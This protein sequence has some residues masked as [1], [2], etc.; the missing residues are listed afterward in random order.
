MK[1]FICVFIIVLSFFQGTIIAQNVTTK[2]ETLKHYKSNIS[3]SKITPTENNAGKSTKSNRQILMLGTGGVVVTSGLI[4]YAIFNSS[5]TNSFAVECN[6]GYT[7]INDLGIAN[8]QLEEFLK[9]SSE[10]PISSIQASQTN[11][12]CQDVGINSITLSVT[13]DL[14]QTAVCEAIVEVKDSISPVLNCPSDVTSNTD[15]GDCEATISIT[16][17]TATDNC[18]LKEVINDITNSSDPPESFQQGNTSVTWIATD[19]YDNFSTCK[20]TISVID[21]EAP[22][23]DCPEVPPIDAE[24]GKCEAFVEVP[25]PTATDN[26]SGNIEILLKST[27]GT[28]ASGVYQVGKTSI[29]WEAKDEAG[30]T[31]T[32]EMIIEVKESEKPKVECPDDVE[33]GTDAE[34]EGCDADVDILLPNASDN[35]AL[36]SVTNS[37][38]NTEDASG[39]YPLGTT[40][41]SWTATDEA[42]NQETCIMEVLI[43]DDDPPDIK[44]PKDTT[45]IVAEDVDEVYVQIDFP[46]VSDNCEIDNVTN[47]YNGTNNASD[48]YPLGTTKVTW[49]ITDMAGLTNTCSHDII[50]LVENELIVECPTILDLDN[51]PGTC[52]ATYPLIDDIV[53]SGA[54]GDFEIISDYEGGNIFPVGSTVVTFTVSDEGANSNSCSTTMNVEDVEAPNIMCPEDQLITVDEGIPSVYVTILFPTI[55]DNC[56]ID[57]VVNDY[58]GTNNA[59]DTYPIGTTNVSWTITDNAG[60]T[61][62][63]THQIT[64][65]EIEEPCDLEIMMTAATNPSDSISFDG[66]MTISTTGGTMPFDLYVVNLDNGIPFFGDSYNSTE[67]TYLGFGPGEYEVYVID[68]EGC[69]SNTLFHFFEVAYLTLPLGNKPSH[70]I[71]I[72]WSEPQTGFNDWIIGTMINDHL[73]FDKMDGYQDLLLRELIPTEDVYSYLTPGRNLFSLQ[74]NTETFSNW[75]FGSSIYYQQGVGLFNSLNKNN[76]NNEI[77]V[78]YDAAGS[79]FSGSINYSYSEKNLYGRIGI[80]AVNSHVKML[81]NYF[82]NNGTRL[83]ESDRIIIDKFNAFLRN[84]ITFKLDNN[85]HYELSTNILLMDH[86]GKLN[87]TP[88]ESLFIYSGL[89]LKL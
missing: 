63:C 38:N 59:S 80:G 79:G 60:L 25:I 5:S 57:N 32:C 51:D 86:E 24:P 52:S 55:S 70:N 22:K 41:V 28:D 4:T 7:Y 54:S 88:T 72:S 89:K 6:N 35:C 3:L 44:C 42:G 64:V 15:P 49:T 31:S 14:Q 27:G 39:T 1:N 37:F 53:V 75:S 40:E 45:I 8:I 65:E 11:F 18:E 16:L 43:F 48:T 17:P 2:D 87:F 69:T 10:S 71:N 33:Q 84:E 29:E 78:M 82:H 34:S 20:M 62:S 46:L 68:S 9:D 23:I 73:N 26:C 76:I 12:I 21:K 66:A 77:K 81:I 83:G 85:L 30:N 61:N 74:F 56:E 47:N 19:V 36:S 50:I 13:N 67:F 58:N